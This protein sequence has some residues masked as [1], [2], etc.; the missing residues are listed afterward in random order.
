METVDKALSRGFDRG[1]DLFI[2]RMNEKKDANSTNEAVIDID[3][4]LKR[5]DS[6]PRESMTKS[7]AWDQLLSFDKFEKDISKAGENTE[8][9]K[10]QQTLK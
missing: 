6:A 4:I 2:E 7:K 9:M 10:T 1:A 5:L 3:K 8:N